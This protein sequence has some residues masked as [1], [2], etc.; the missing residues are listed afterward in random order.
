MKAGQ[1]FNRKLNAEQVNE[2]GKVARLKPT[3]P[4]KYCGGLQPA[5]Q[6]SVEKLG[7]TNNELLKTYGVQLATGEMHQVE[8]KMLQAPE[9]VYGKKTGVSN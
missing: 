3:D 1:S 4:G 8:A 7:L 9:L 2:M 5:I 6:K